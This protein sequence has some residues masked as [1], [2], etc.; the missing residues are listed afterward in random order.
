MPSQS[1]T[2]TDLRPEPGVGRR[3]GLYPSGKGA[4]RYQ[5]KPYAT[6]K[7]NRMPST[8]PTHHQVPN[9]GLDDFTVPG[10]SSSRLALLAGL[11][12]GLPPL[13]EDHGQHGESPHG[14]A[15]HHQPKVAF[16]PTAAS[17]ATER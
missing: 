15:A 3:F 14:V 5:P 16:R 6:T 10:T 2:R 11:L 17:S 13:P 8:S 12:Q 7:K 1:Q 9:C 4:G